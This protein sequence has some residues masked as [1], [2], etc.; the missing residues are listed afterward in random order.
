[1]DKAQRKAL[2]LPTNDDFTIEDASKPQEI[3]MNE[4][5][6]GNKAKSVALPFGHLGGGT[7]AGEIPDEEMEE[8]KS[9]VFQKRDRCFQVLAQVQLDVQHA[10]N[11]WMIEERL[12][13]VDTLSKAK[14]Y[15]Q[16]QEKHP[17]RGVVR[18]A[19]EAEEL[20][21]RFNNM[22]DEET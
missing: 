18:T 14:D 3:E 16:L 19:D 21:E 4:P 13:K 6:L 17:L 11:L 22:A 10:E 9:Q 8:E 12:K 2:G 20:A 1:M 5:A 7:A 15:G